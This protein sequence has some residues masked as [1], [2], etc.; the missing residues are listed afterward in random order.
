MYNAPAAAMHVP[1]SHQNQIQ[2]KMKKTVLIT[3]SSSGIGKAAA[4]YFIKNGWNVAATMR[5]PEAEKDL[6]ESDSLRLIRLDVQ[7]E[8]S[9]AEAVRQ[10]IT[11]FGKIDVLVNNAGYGLI[12]VAEFIN[13]ADIRRQFDVN[14][15]GLMAVTNA[16][17]PHFRASKSGRIINVSSMG[18]RVTFPLFSYYH[19]TKFAI[20]GY[21]ES[22][23]YELNP[24]GIDVKIIEPGGVKTDFGGR[25]LDMV[26]TDSPDYQRLQD[27]L[28]E[29]LSN[30]SNIPTEAKDVAK[31]IF[32]AATTRDNRMRYLVGSD[33]RMMWTIKRLF[34]A[35]GQQQVVKSFY[36]I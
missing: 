35:R 19:A 11:A 14:V 4:N 36:K 34:G 32:Q 7:D 17:L 8:A 5:K 9:I 2:Q 24:L 28:V 3:G 33:A 15:F 13:E 1:L 26:K 18:G 23:N 31:V 16:V 29:A 10:T 27:K 6:Q 21:S 25:S 12:G 22:L 20:E 30:S